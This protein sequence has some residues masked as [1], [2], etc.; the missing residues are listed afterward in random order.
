MT[1]NEATGVAPYR[2]VAAA[3]REDI[4]RGKYLIGQRI[5]SN[6]ELA[7]HLDVSLPTVVKAIEEL[8]DEGMVE[9]RRGRGTFVRARQVFT[10]KGAARYTRTPGGL[11]PNMAE[12]K[13]GGWHDTVTAERWR[14]PASENVAERLRI[15][16]G[17][18]VTV[19]RYLWLVAD[20]PI[21]VGTQY[22]PLALTAG[23]PIEE[24]VDG[25]RGNPGVISRFDSIG[26]HVDHVDEETRAMMP[27]AEESRLLQLGS[28]IP[29]LKVTRTHWAGDT[30]VETADIAIRGD[31]MSIVAR[32]DVPLSEGAS[33][34]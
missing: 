22:E 2:Q 7:D 12:A 10:R 4:V 15:A 25:T 24:P 11:A 33:Q 5:P 30:P 3:L 16:P 17:D 8:R 31:R 26:L 21:Q 1:I 6:R 29:I 20:R 14:E 19:A 32:H 27:S 28:G 13:A 9:T 34:S 23:T 18:P